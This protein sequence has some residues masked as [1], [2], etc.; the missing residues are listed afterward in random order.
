MLLVAGFGPAIAQ[1]SHSDDEDIESAKKAAMEYYAGTDGTA[2][3]ECNFNVN[4]SKDG[5]VQ[6]P[7]RMIILT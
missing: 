1:G 5:K 3:G 4:V 7:G 6:A 2:E